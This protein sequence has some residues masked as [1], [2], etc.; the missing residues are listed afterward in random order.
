MLRSII[1]S[2]SAGD[3]KDAFKA[4][5]TRVREFLSQNPALV[6][7][8]KRQASLLNA[9]LPQ[10][11]IKMQEK[12]KEPEKKRQ[13]LTQ[14]PATVSSL[15]VIAQPQPQ[16]EVFVADEDLID[17]TSVDPD[18]VVHT[19]NQPQKQPDDSNFVSQ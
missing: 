7:D 5:E 1:T 11:D 2:R 6:L 16:R 18:T 15:R 3:A 14:S 10:Q 12:Q 9:T 8:A 19:E 13:D 4:Y 17:W